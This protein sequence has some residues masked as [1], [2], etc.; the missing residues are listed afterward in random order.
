MNGGVETDDQ[1]TTDRNRLEAKAGSAGI[2]MGEAVKGV[3][4]AFVAVPSVA[5]VHADRA[6]LDQVPAMVLVELRR[7]IAHL[8]ADVDAALARHLA[9]PERPVHNDAA[10]RL[11]TPEE[12]AAKYGVTKRWLLDHADDIPGVRRLSP[13]VIRFHERALRRH[14]SG[15]KA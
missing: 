8:G 11:L 15:V 2:V 9:R 4:R 5:D 10:D 12:A 3:A 14:L 13:K 7:Q 6:L 1:R